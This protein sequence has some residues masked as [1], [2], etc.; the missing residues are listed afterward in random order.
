MIINAHKKLE[1]SLAAIAQWEPYIGAFV[2][3]TEE[4]ARRQVAVL[5]TDAAVQEQPLAGM[6]IAI[7]ENIATTFGH[8]NASS[9]ILKDFVS[10]YNAS[11][12]QKLLQAGAVVVGKTQ[13]DELGMGSSTEN[14]GVGPHTKNPW[15]ISRVAGGSSGGSAAAV[16]SGEVDYAFGTDTGGSIRQPACLCG[17][18]GVKPT[19]GRVSRH[20]LIAY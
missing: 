3:L 14:I 12:V 19:Y 15:D 11:V 1:E 5:K 10:P 13:E 18:V 9:R 4:E 7:K 8:T 16:A 20:G 6:T 17:V 2:E